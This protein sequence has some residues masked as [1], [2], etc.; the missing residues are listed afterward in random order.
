[1]T[2]RKREPSFYVLLTEAINHFAINGFRTKKDLDHWVKRL[3]TSIE[4]TLPPTQVTEKAIRRNLM[5]VYRRMIVSKQ[6]FKPTPKGAKLAPLPLKPPTAP[7]PLGMKIAPGVSKFTI[8]KMKPAARAEL[9]RRI[10]ASVNLIKLNREEAIATTLRRFEGWVS[11]VPPSGAAA[12]DKMQLK[13]H[14][15][16]PLA[17]VDFRERQV[18]MDQTAKFSQALNSAIAL[19]GKAIAGRWYSRWKVAGYDY[20]EDHKERDGLYYAVPDNWAIRK[21]LMKPGP[22]GYTTDITQPAEEVNCKCSYVYVFG[23]ADL[24]DEMLTEKGR[25]SLQGKNIRS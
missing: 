8:D 12:L 22:H 1:M 3:K 10:L 6:T 21:G 18:V 24:P 23:L 2:K 15:R 20:R 14:I 4:S 19:N 17:R 16:A 13:Q 9:E 7:L 11:S 25:Q 5:D